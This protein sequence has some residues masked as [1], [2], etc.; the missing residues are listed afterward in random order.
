MPGA[1]MRRIKIAPDMYKEVRDYFRTSMSGSGFDQ[2]MV[3]MLELSI[4]EVIQNIQRHGYPD[5][6]GELVLDVSYDEEKITVKVKDWAKPFNLV[7]Y[8]PMEKDK[9]FDKGIKG[10]LG[11]GMIKKIC[12]ELH[13]MT[14]GGMNST[15]MVKY[16]KKP[17]IPILSY[18]KPNS[19]DIILVFLLIL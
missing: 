6:K 4:D 2:D 12:D 3:S 1:F 8:N 10:K 13:Y 5:G 7:E 11:I 15:I 17:E 14:E 19:I 18:I 9:L 16:R